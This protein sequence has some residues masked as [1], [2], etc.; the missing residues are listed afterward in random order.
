MAVEVNQ[1]EKTEGDAPDKED[2]QDDRVHRFALLSGQHGGAD[3]VVGLA[4]HIPKQE[5]QNA[6]RDRVEEPL[7]A[8]R[9]PSKASRRQAKEDRQSR[10]RP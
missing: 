3:R 6:Q 9:Q 10:K 7:G 8:S 2:D 5:D 1:R 4:Q